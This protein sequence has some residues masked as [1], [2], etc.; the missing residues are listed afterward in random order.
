MPKKR[1][2]MWDLEP[3]ET[4]ISVI[5][6]DFDR[7][8]DYVLNHKN[9]VTKKTGSLNRQACFE[10][11]GLLSFHQTYEKPTRNQ[12][13]YPVIQLFAGVAVVLKLLPD[14]LLT[15]PILYAYGKLKTFSDFQA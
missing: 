4:E 8:C 5:C 12:Q 15:S 6:R 2:P 9:I 10:I 1:Q 13:A 14:V 11:N 7:F 3:Y